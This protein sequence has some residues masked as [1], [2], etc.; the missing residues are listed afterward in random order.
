MAGADIERAFYVRSAGTT[1]ARLVRHQRPTTPATC[2][3]MKPILHCA[4]ACAARPVE[5]DTAVH[6]AQ[7]RAARAPAYTGPT[8]GMAGRHPIASWRPGAPDLGAGH[9]SGPGSPPRRPRRALHPRR[10]RANAGAAAGLLLRLDWQQRRCL[11]RRYRWRRRWRLRPQ[12]AVGAAIGRGYDYR[13]IHS[14]PAFRGHRRWGE[15]PDL[16]RRQGRLPPARAGPRS[17]PLRLSTKG[18]GGLQ[19]HSC[20]HRRRPDQTRARRRPPL[21]AP[22]GPTT[23]TT[24]TTTIPIYSQYRHFS[25]M[26]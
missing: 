17:G 6:A 19:R 3:H 8:R 14:T 2:E 15:H 25:I 12:R 9:W 16:G 22:A 23:T 10:R 5:A 20:R 11:Q 13:G 21:S 7:K 24:T 26:C 18:M 4:A 1:T